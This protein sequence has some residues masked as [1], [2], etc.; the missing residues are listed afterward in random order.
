[1]SASAPR[2]ASGPFTAPAGPQAAIGT[3][4]TPATSAAPPP[5]QRFLARLQLPD[6]PYGL[7]RDARQQIAGT[8]AAPDGSAR[9]GGGPTLTSAFAPIHAADG[10]RTALL[11]QLVAHD[12]AGAALPAEA[13]FAGAA[14]DDDL[15]A[16]DRRARLIHVLNFFRIERAAL[17]ICLPVHP[18]LLAAVTTDHGRAF[19]RVTDSL[20]L[21]IG[22]VAIVLPALPRGDLDRLVNV[23]ASYRLNGFQVH[24][25]PSDPAQVRALIARI[26]PDAVRLMRNWLGAADAG[27]AVAALRAAGL[28]VIATGVDAVG[29]RALAVELGATHLQG[30]VIGTPFE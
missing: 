10:A 3:P 28:P 19:R 5:L 17:T 22:R 21:P 8:V 14:S 7:W 2:P 16:L 23:V 26:R 27:A 15:V 29:L 24:V 13:L 4:G 18:R 1:M 30:D 12:A 6:P 11:A 20:G 9:A 25:T